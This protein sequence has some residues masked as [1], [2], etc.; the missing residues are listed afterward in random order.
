M[1]YEDNPPCYRISSV[2]PAGVCASVHRN[3][4]GGACGSPAA[5]AGRGGTAGR[6]AAAP[7]PEAPGPESVNREGRP[8]G[9]AAGDGGGAMRGEIGR[10]HV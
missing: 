6:R 3:A 7:Q 4:G 8:T 10:A 9:C 1:R 5:R 2:S